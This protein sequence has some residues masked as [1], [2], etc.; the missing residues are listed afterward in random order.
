MAG[1]SGIGRQIGNQRIHRLVPLHLQLGFEG[2]REWASGTATAAATGGTPMLA[3]QVGLLQGD[4]AR[5]RR[6]VVRPADVALMSALRL[7]SWRGRCSAAAG[8]PIGPIVY[9]RRSIIR[10]TTAVTA[11]TGQIVSAFAA[12]RTH[13]I[14]FCMFVGVH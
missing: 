3:G 10:R 11:G 2:R 14:F 5:R 6:G 4:A 9:V 8:D 7:K 13:L 12:G 1:S